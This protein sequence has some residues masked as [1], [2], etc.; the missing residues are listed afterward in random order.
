MAANN[1]GESPG[2]A[3]RGAEHKAAASKSRAGSRFYELYPS[4]TSKR[5]TRRGIRGHH[6]DLLFVIGA[7]FDP[8]SEVAA[9]LSK[10]WQ[11]GGLL[12]LNESEKEKIGSAMKKASEVQ[13][14]HHILA[15]TLELG[16]DLALAP[17][18]NVSESPGFE[19][20]LGIFG[21]ED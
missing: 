19:A 14:F 20:F 10:S 12:I 16:Y 1:S 11:D 9:S 18:L 21:G 13:K 6:E 7:G 5:A 2:F 3:G 15:Y 17:G 4:K 8:S